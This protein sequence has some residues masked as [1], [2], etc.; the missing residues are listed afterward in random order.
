VRVRNLRAE[1]LSVEILGWLTIALS[2]FA[3]WSDSKPVSDE[4][5]V[6]RGINGLAASMG[7]TVWI[8]VG[9][10]LASESGAS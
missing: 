10:G 9:A 7:P 3:V 8:P 4:I 5:L 1:A 2:A 6:Q